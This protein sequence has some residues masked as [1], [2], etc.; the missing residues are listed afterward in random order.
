MKITCVGGGPAGLYLAVLAARRDPRHRITVLERNPEGATSGW[1]VVF[2]DDLL[3]DLYRNDPVSAAALRRDAVLYQG[4][5][6]LLDGHPAA[7]LGG[8][9][10]SIGRRRLLEILTGRARELGVDVRF[11]TPA[12]DAA[13]AGADLVVAA[14]GVSSGLRSRHAEAFGTAETVGRNSYIWLGTDK[15]FDTFTFAFAHTAAGW[16][17]FH[18]YPCAEG[19]STCIVECAPEVRAGLGLDGPDPDAHIARLEQLFAGPLGGRRLLNRAPGQQPAPWM[20]FHE[21]RNTT[22]CRGR[23]VLVGD[24][25]HTTH[26]SIGSGT[27]LALRDAIELAALLP[28]DTTRIDERLHTYD[29]RRRAALGPIQDAARRSMAWFEHVDAHLGPEPGAVDPVLFAYDLW[30]RRGQYPLWRYHLHL[31]TQVAT[32]RTARRAV[33][34]VRRAVRERWRPHAPVGTR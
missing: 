7:H 10:Y 31:A 12:D 17:W 28:S 33:G 29:V 5:T 26:F 2:W 25:A 4:Q 16:I 1:G 22:W 27:K 14:D 19:I 6:V 30:R 13:T 18:A 15:V 24:A 21:I 9:G 11:D 23:T 32:V 20:R 3:D 8:Y 34:T